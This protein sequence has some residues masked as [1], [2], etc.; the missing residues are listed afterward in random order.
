LKLQCIT[1][2]GERMF[3]IQYISQLVFITDSMEDCH[4]RSLYLQGIV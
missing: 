4:I 2:L 3:M 1:Y